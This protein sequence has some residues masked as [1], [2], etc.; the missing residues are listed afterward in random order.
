M[1]EEGEYDTGEDILEEEEDCA[2][3]AEPCDFFDYRSKCK[4][5]SEE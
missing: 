4:G 3:G 1:S 5:D 2:S